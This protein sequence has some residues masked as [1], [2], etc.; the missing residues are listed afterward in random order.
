MSGGALVAE[1]CALAFDRAPSSQAN[2]AIARAREHVGSGGAPGLSYEVVLPELAP[3]EFLAQ[4]VLPRLVGYLVSRGVRLPGSGGVFVSLFTPD[5]LFFVD[6]G[7]F[8]LAL[9][10]ARGLD[11]DELVRR[12]RPDG[13][14]DPKLLGG[15]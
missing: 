10:R 1:V 14:G 4:R 8:A 7:P 12:Y 3:D 2:E 9:G 15:A 13:P 6:A 11:A 5:G